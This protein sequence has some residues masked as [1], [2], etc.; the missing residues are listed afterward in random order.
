MA[1]SSILTPT[2]IGDLTFQKFRDQAR[3]V[4]FATWYLG[5]T[6]FGGPAYQELFAICNATPGPGSTKMLFNI[7]VIRGGFLAGILA[8]LMW[9]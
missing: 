6:A 4:V 8:F 2:L 7:V 1:L 9:R 3:D 5:V